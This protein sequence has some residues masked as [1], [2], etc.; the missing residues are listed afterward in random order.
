[1]K[2]SE[3]TRAAY[4]SEEGFVERD[5]VR[6]FWEA[7]GEGEETLLLLP[8][9]S[10]VHSRQWKAQIPYLSRHFRVVT[11]D[12]RGN[13]RSDRPPDR[14][15]YAEREFAADALEVMEATGT[16]RAVIAGNS[17]GAQRGMLLCAEHPERVAG[18][19]FIGPWFPVA[20]LRGLRWRLMTNPRVIALFES[21]RPISTRSWLKFNAQHMRSRLPRLRRVVRRSLPPRGAL[22]QA[23]R[24]HDRLGRGDRPRCADPLGHRRAGRPERS[25]QPA[26]AGAAGPLPGAGDPRQAR[27]DHP[28][29]Q[30]SRP[31]A[32]HRRGDDR[33]RRRRARAAR[34]PAGAGE[35]GAAGV[36]R[37]GLR[38]R[39][40]IRG[41]GSAG[42]RGAPGS[43]R[44]SLRRPAARPLHLLADRA[45]ARPAR[46]R[47]R[48]GAA[49]PGPRP[50]DRLARPGSGD[51]GAGA[52][53]RDDPPGERAPGQRVRATSSRSR[54]STICT[55]S[56]PGGGWTRS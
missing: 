39:R 3:Q 26:R 50:A 7:Y 56:R 55:A 29:R 5:G 45:R 11:F 1:M 51:P 10:L 14:D 30:R 27:P 52:R 38:P 9:W 24:G 13:G 36:R 43:H 31:G 12:G 6:V 54:P 8:T 33:A 47:D 42:F 19:V 35:P 28:C 32:R 41:R 37:A 46:R 44:A 48:Q 23:D 4:P 25:P 21:R 17:R 15:G 18:A 16:E 53:G 49:Q 2:D 40:S 20:P 22:H 34:A